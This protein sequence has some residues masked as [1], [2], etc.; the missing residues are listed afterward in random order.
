VALQDALQAGAVD[1]VAANAPVEVALVARRELGHAF[2]VRDYTRMQRALREAEQRCQ[3]LLEGSRAAIAY[4][5]EGMHIYA[6][7]AYLRL[8]RF[9]GADDLLGLPLMDL[10]AEAGA[11]QLKDALKAMRESS[12]FELQFSGT[13][14]KGDPVSGQME[15][16]SAEYEGEKCLQV[17]VRPSTVT[18]PED[19]I[20][21]ADTLVTQPAQTS[22]AA[23]LNVF[24]EQVG[25]FIEEREDGCALFVVALDGYDAHEATLGVADARMLADQVQ[26]IVHAR[27]DRALAFAID[28]RRLA[29]FRCVSAPE[30]ALAE[31]DSLRREIEGREFDITA[32]AVRATVT[33]TGEYALK[34]IRTTELLDI[35]AARLTSA[36]ESGSN[37][38]VMPESESGGSLD[39]AALAAL[40]RINEAIEQAAFALVYQPII[41]LRGDGEEHYE[42]Y[43]RLTTPSGELKSPGDF[44]EEAIEQNVASKIDRWVVLESIK[45]LSA[46]RADG[47]NTRL[48]INLTRNSVTDPEFVQWLKVAIKAARMPADAVIFQFAEDDARHN[49][50]QTR[51]FVNGLKELHVRASLN[52]FCCSEDAFQTLSH[53]PV[54]YVKLSG[55]AVGRI[56]GGGVGREQMSDALKR[57][58][59]D[60]KL[61]VVPMVE[62]AALLATLWQAGANYIQGHYL[63]EASQ[64]LD[65]DFEADQH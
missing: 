49:V 36:L 15:L 53:L 23:S 64:Q 51:V 19:A 65:Y 62:S 3:L 26:S 4:V 14:C 45:T 20:P 18:S 38:V 44:L 39:R 58:Q 47:H 13:T 35:A 22:Y 11:Q 33:I 40:A 12:H 27:L 52:R 31:L 60:G 55:A 37:R 43:L 1:V 6:N 17:T 32:R 24:A 61:T 50:R 9:A 41:S 56:D 21:P 57:L 25:R 5:H 10:T 7:E 42:A 54:D 28:H 63:Q 8:F 29:L 16:Q 48:T 46:H 30:Q 2:K 34:D 59:A